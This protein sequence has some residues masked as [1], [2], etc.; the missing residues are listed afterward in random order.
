MGTWTWNLYL[1]IAWLVR[2]QS[3]REKGVTEYW[4]GNENLNNRHS[5]GSE[6][7]LNGCERNNNNAEVKK[8]FEFEESKEMKG[9][10][11]KCSKLHLKVRKQ[12]SAFIACIVV[13][14]ILN[15]QIWLEVKWWRSATHRKWVRR[16]EGS[17]DKR[18]FDKKERR[19][20]YKWLHELSAKRV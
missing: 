18:W 17:S 4:C 2:N 5:S 1:L 19:K 15:L 13:Y 8:E 12:S 9:G 3:G 14:W 11:K 7:N 20:E 6:G 10:W 16:R